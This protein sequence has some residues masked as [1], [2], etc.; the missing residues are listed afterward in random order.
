MDQK[1]TEVLSLSSKLKDK[2][3]VIGIAGKKGV[4]K[5]TTANVLVNLFNKE[6]NVIAFQMSFA[7][8]LKQGLAAF[9]G[10]NVDDLNDDKKKEEIDSY[11]GTSPRKV[12][13]WFGTEVFR[14]KISELL[15][16]VKNEE[17]WSKRMDLDIEKHIK[18]WDDIHRQGLTPIKSFSQLGQNNPPI[19]PKYIV[20]I[21]DVRFPNEVEYIQSFKK[22]A[23]IK[24]VRQTGN[25]DNHASE[26]SVDDIQNCD[27]IIGNNFSTV[28]LFENYVKMTLGSLH[29]L[30]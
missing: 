5:D 7:N 15:P 3:T 6:E 20:I 28:H 14:K 25:T 16:E 22:H 17:F 12:M 18:K 19:T 27:F 4:G 8:P 10:W 21:S 9:F 30:E 26:K 13:Q 2:V 23:V 1:S 24:V 11:W 29:C